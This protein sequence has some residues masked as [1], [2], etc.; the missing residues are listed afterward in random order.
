MKLRLLCLLILYPLFCFP[1]LDSLKGKPRLVKDSMTYINPAMGTTLTL[2]CGVDFGQY[3]LTEESI[4]QELNK[5]GMFP[6]LALS[7]KTEKEYDKKGRLIRLQRFD[8]R[9]SF[10]SIY[11][12][13][14][15]EYGNMV[16]EQRTFLAKDY[17]SKDVT[18]FS[19]HAYKDSVDRLV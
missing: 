16:Q 3:S 9:H 18:N 17:E 14:F 11:T 10:K 7:D 8:P 2:R 1:Q 5:Q 12:Y 19:Y 15:D 6:R 13:A 4:L